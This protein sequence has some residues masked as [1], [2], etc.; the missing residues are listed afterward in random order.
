YRR[1]QQKLVR[2]CRREGAGTACPFVPPTTTTT[3]PPSVTLEVA[4][5][6]VETWCDDGEPSRV[7]QQ[8]VVTVCAHDGARIT[9]DP[10]LFT[11]TTDSPALPVGMASY[12]T[13]W[14]QY[15]YGVGCEGV[16]ITAQPLDGPLSGQV[17]VACDQCLLTFDVPYWGEDRRLTFSD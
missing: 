1:C 7:G 17:S 11:L 10:D 3:L 9:L 13:S 2:K 15:D 8:F 5:T 12:P 6:T 16:S 4:P 14:C